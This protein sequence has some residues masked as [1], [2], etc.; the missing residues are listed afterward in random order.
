[1]FSVCIL[2]VTAIAAA[3]SQH[4]PLV[5]RL[6]STDV[7]IRMKAV[8]ELEHAAAVDPVVVA[9]GAVQEALVTL[10]EAEN[11]LVAHNYRSVAAEALRN[12]R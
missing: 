4:Q 10:V 1:M 11:A 5:G 8:A 7:R 12:L 3:T 2:F 6:T 9:D